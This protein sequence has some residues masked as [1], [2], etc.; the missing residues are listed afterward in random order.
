MAQ[1]MDT[2]RDVEVDE[3]QYFNDM[4][5]G[6]D[7]NFG[8]LVWNIDKERWIVDE[9]QEFNRKLHSIPPEMNGMV[10]DPSTLSWKG[11]DSALETFNDS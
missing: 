4:V 6:P 10:W 9:A 3:A 11:N 1:I 8:P 5:I 2:W 7:R